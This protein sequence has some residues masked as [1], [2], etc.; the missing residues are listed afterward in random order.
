MCI[1]DRKVKEVLAMCATCPKI[2]T[3]IYS[4]HMT[5][6]KDALSAADIASAKVKVRDNTT[7]RRRD[8]ATPCPIRRRLA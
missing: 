2:T 6:A 1:R 8:D 4:D 3:I 7:T 5:T